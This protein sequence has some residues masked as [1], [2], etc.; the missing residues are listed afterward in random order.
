[1]Y[2]Q[3]VPIRRCSTWGLAPAI[4]PLLLSLVL[5]SPAR[6]AEGNEAAKAEKPKLPTPEQVRKPAI[7]PAAVEMTG[8]LGYRWFMQDVENFN[9]SWVGGF[10]LG[11]HLDPIATFEATAWYSQAKTVERDKTAHLGFLTGGF[12]F[13]L[14]PRSPV[15]PYLGIG[16]GVRASNVPDRP[17]G[18]TARVDEEGNPLPAFR[19]PDVDFLWDVALGVKVFLGRRVLLRA[20]FRYAMVVGD[21]TEAGTTLDGETIP[22]RWDHL[23]TTAGVAVLIGGRVPDVDSDRD[24]IID[25]EDYCPYESEDKDGFEDGDGCVDPD[26]DGDGAVDKMDTCPNEPET[27]NEF[28]DLDGCPDEA[29]LPPPPQIL[30]EAPP[31][32]P[33]PPPPQPSVETIRRFS[34]V[35]EGLRFQPD[36]VDFTPES[37]TP[38]NQAAAVLKEYPSLR[39]EVSGH[40]SAEGDEA[41]NRDLSQRRAEAVARYLTNLGVGAER[42]LAVGY[43]EDQ[44]LTDNTSPASRERNRR[45][46]F[47]ILSQ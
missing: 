7:L 6:A 36:S 41:H 35:I 12:L 47:R 43:G 32:V 40:A 13:H 25:R 15:V 29:P 19:N 23:Q 27:L 44:P 20:D 3:S 16:A 18:D 8:A 46:E 24:G 17:A 34:G 42:L 33:L 39:V 21:G 9:D 45:V 22:D 10:L 31:P 26:N 37:F 5:P 28:R 38:L 2:S 1:M 30:V 14:T 4:L 11:V